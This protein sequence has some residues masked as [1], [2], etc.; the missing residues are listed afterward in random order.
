MTK[1][2]TANDQDNNMVDADM[3]NEVIWTKADTAE[4]DSPRKTPV[5]ARDAQQARRQQ[6]LVNEIMLFVAYVVA[7]VAL[8]S[9]FDVASSGSF[10]TLTF[11]FIISKM[12]VGAFGILALYSK[13]FTVIKVYAGAF[14]MVYGTYAVWYTCNAVAHGDEIARTNCQHIKAWYGEERE[15]CFHRAWYLLILEC[16]MDLL[17]SIFGFALTWI[18]VDAARKLKKEE[19]HEDAMKSAA[20]L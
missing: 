13:Q 3:V 11:F 8:W 14:L 19:E 5:T 10:I 17:F 16:V 6:Q 9:A 18:Y 20:A 15:E 4:P 2:D 1:E 7:F 12:M